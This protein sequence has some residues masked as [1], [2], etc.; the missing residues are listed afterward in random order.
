MKAAFIP[1]LE[2]HFS[3]GPLEVGDQAVMPISNLK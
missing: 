1:I 3:S 2:E